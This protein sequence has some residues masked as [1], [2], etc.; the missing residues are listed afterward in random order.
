MAPR[1]HKHAFLYSVLA[2]LLF[3]FVGSIG[4][5]RASMSDNVF[6]YAWSSNIG[7]VKLNN[8]SASGTCSG[9]SYGVSFQP[10]GS[11]AGSGYAW[12]PN[13]GWISFNA[14]AVTGCPSGF[15]QCGAYADWA[16]PNGD[17][18]VNIKGW[19]RACAVFASGCSGALKAST[20]L[21]GWDGFI[22]L[23]DT[24]SG[25]ASWGLSI[26]SGSIEGYAWGSD[27]VGWL[28][29]YGVQYVPGDVT[30]A[31]AANPSSITE[32]ETSFLEWSSTN[33]T[34]C[35]GTNFATGGAVNGSLWV[36]PMVTI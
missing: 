8:C 29:M 35:S 21:G 32:G 6:G 17:G 30:A 11:G 20:A 15:S 22:A 18:S 26:E 9:P 12:S 31:I 16:S 13:I 24:A 28:G 33:A 25:G 36:S 19:A 10:S 23:G 1:H 34:S 27:V 2:L 7:W 3:F 5:A 4:N 14:S